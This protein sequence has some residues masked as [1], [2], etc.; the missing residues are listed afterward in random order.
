MIFQGHRYWPSFKRL[1]KSPLGLRIR[2]RGELR[3]GQLLQRRTQVKLTNLLF[4]WADRM[5]S[6]RFCPCRCDAAER[7]AILD[8]RTRPVILLTLH[9]G[10]EFVL[11]SW[12]RSRGL[13]AAM[14][15]GEGM[16]PVAAG[17]SLFVKDRDR[18]AGLEGIPTVIEAGCIG[19][20]YDHLAANRI[21][22]IDV[23]GAWGRHLATPE[24]DGLGLIMH[25]GSLKL[26]AMTGAVVMPCL[27]TSAPFFGFTVHLGEPIPEALITNQRQHKMAC[28]HAF[29][30]FL[31]V[32]EQAPEECTARLLDRFVTT[33][34]QLPRP[35]AAAKL[36]VRQ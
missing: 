20:M 24:M 13:P 11:V 17:R 30:A 1:R 15:G 14:V 29:R 9:F 36:P 10:P 8:S 27:I 16:K 18:L 5:K 35:S 19:E 28:E 25:T 12:L 6:P 31:P 4:L 2:R 33:A 3:F 21:L 34:N 22:I 23:D 32:L 7:L 26:A